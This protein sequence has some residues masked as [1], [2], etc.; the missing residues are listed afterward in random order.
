MQVAV[1]LPVWGRLDR[2]CAWVQFAAGM[3]REAAKKVRAGGVEEIPLRT[4][5][6][7]NLA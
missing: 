7:W 2:E 4:W 3:D 6:V 1:E 5:E